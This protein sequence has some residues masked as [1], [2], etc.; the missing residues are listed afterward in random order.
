MIVSTREEPRL[1]ELLSKYD[2]RWTRLGVVGGARLTL[3]TADRRLLDLPVARLHQAWMSL[4][5]L[6]TSG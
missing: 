4:E 6:L 5:A 1:R 3:T 2:L